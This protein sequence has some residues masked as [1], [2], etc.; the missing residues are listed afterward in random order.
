[1]LTQTRFFRGYVRNNIPLTSWPTITHRILENS[2][3][4]CLF[5]WNIYIFHT[6]QICFRSQ[7][8]NLKLYFVWTNSKW[9]VENQSGGSYLYI[10]KALLVYISSLWRLD[11]KIDVT[12]DEEHT[13]NRKYI[14]W[15]ICSFHD[16]TLPMTGW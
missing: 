13:R 6:C 15:V 11:T 10:Y 7:L 2:R 3:T 8:P 12:Y 14:I 9:F 1:M 5:W 16:V 4:I